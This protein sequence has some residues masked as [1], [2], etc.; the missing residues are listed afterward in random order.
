MLSPETKAELVELVL[1]VIA[2]LVMVSLV[3]MGLWVLIEFM[4]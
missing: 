4:I 1:A 2:Y 3:L